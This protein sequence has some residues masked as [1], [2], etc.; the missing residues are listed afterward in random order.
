[1]NLA[2]LKVASCFISLFGF[3][4]LVH[5]YEVETHVRISQKAATCSVLSNQ[6]FVSGLGLKSLNDENPVW[7][8]PI[9]DQ[10]EK[11]EEWILKW[12]VEYG[13]PNDPG[14]KSTIKTLI[15]WGAKFEDEKFLT[16][17]LNHFFDPLNGL[18][19]HSCPHGADCNTSPA[20][21]L[22]DGSPHPDLDEQEQ[23]FFDANNRLRYALGLADK[24]A[25]GV[26]KVE[27]M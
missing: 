10:D 13:D 27:G 14:Y 12:I 17:P 1:M 22:E 9:D 18:P 20:W 3:M 6:E 4:Q 8:K 21:A 26:W 7:R 15:G 25:R 16:R 24:D 2:K 11:P 5:A 19:F 23:S